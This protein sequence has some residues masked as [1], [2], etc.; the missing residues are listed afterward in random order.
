MSPVVMRAQHKDSRPNIIYIMA[1]DLGYADLSCYGQKK[2]NTPNIDR[3]AAQG[4]KFTN[5]YA[6][7]PVCTPTRAAFM[8]GRYPA[9]TEVGLH[10]PLDWSAE[11]S[12]IGL[13]PNQFTIGS[14]LQKAGYETLLVGKWHLGFQPENSPMKN[15]FD[16]FFGI[17]GGGIDY[18]SHRAP[19]N[20]AIDL[21]EN[22]KPVEQ[23][24]YLTE[25]LQKKTIEL[26]E[27][28]H[29]KPFFLAL[30]F[31]APHWPWQ[32]PG[33]AKYPDNMR[34][35]SGGSPEVYAQMVKSMDDAVGE[36]IKTI[37]E[38]NLSKNTV[39]IFTSDNGGEKFSD[40]GIYK[41]RKMQLWEGGIREPA[42]LRWP[43]RVKAGTITNQ[44]T[45]TMDWTATILK[46]ANASPPSSVTLDGI[47]IMPIVTGKKKETDR[48]LYWRISQRNT[49]SAVRDGKWK[50]LKDEKGTEYL[51]DLIADPSEKNNLKESQPAIFEKLRKKY[52]QWA[53][54][55]LTPLPLQKT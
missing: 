40:M 29:E 5:A 1:D 15:G 54:A 27:K 23:N 3:L 13:Q 53:S 24:G 30:M 11:D 46:L 41:G 51:F 17:H 39:I 35:A 8:T 28:K 49:H 32:A 42:M 48:T 55:M 6:A 33:D 47:D 50:Y 20:G 22:E 43:G 9:R 12:T 38:K 45:T 44:V 34:W 2:Y 36:I 21:Y 37:D 19:Q 31:N 4:V 7:A 10:E 18:V 14:L 26:I 52:D 16:Y 25:L